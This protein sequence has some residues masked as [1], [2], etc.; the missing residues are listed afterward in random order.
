MRGKLYNSSLFIFSNFSQIINL[1][2]KELI[3]LYLLIHSLI[4]PS[5]HSLHALPIKRVYCSSVVAA[6]AAVADNDDDEEEE[7]AQ[8][9]KTI[10]PSLVPVY[11]SIV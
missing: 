9:R 4:S 11:K 8:E 6:A 5:V 3:I 1:F 2:I 7:A 10:K